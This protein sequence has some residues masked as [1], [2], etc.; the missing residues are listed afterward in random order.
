M[1]RFFDMQSFSGLGYYT[2]RRYLVKWAEM[3]CVFRIAY[4]VL[5]I[6]FSPAA[7]RLIPDEPRSLARVNLIGVRLQPI[8]LGSPLQRAWLRSAGY[9]RSPR[10]ASDCGAECPGMNARATQLRPINGASPLQ[11]A[12]LRSAGYLRSPRARVTQRIADSWNEQLYTVPARA[13]DAS[14]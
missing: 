5:R 7:R 4:F 6:A 8:A 13:R 11:R 12:W 1:I 2:V 3:Q 14:G 9:L 10:E